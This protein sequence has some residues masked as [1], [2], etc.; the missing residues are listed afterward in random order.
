MAGRLEPRRLVLH[1]G[2]VEVHV[3]VEVDELSTHE[4][5]KLKLMSWQRT[6]E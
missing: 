5:M 2:K 6:K 1:H 3:E 4:R